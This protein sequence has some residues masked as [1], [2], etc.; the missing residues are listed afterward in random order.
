MKNNEIIENK[1]FKS[2]SEIDPLLAFWRFKNKKIVFTNGCFDILHYG[3]VKYLAKAADKGDILIIG[4]NTDTSVKAL[5]G[6]NRPIVDEQSR[7]I[8]LASLHFVDAVVL[9]DEE[10][11]K[12]IIEYIKPRILVKG[13]DYNPA[14]IVGYDF[15]TKTGGTVTTIELAKGFSTSSIIEKISGKIS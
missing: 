15:V 1:F 6:D 2:Y 10:T 13:G 14:E 7:G 5:K 12:R 3:H 4:L 8:L 9:F 11:P